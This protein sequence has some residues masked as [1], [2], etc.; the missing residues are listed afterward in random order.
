M[1]YCR[2]LPLI[3]TFSLSRKLAQSFYY[4]FTRWRYSHL[5]T[6]SFRQTMFYDTNFLAPFGAFGPDDVDTG[7]FL[8]HISLLL[9]SSSTLSGIFTSELHQIQTP[10][11]DRG[12]R[13]DCRT[14]WVFR[15]FGSTDCA[16]LSTSLHLAL[17]IYLH[18]ALDIFH[19]LCIFP[20]CYVT[21]C[22]AHLFISFQFFALWTVLFTS[23]HL[24]TLSRSHHF[25]HDA[26]AALHS[27]T[28][29][30]IL[31]LFPIFSSSKSL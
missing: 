19:I 4:I 28:P 12:T 25:P 11:D 31:P 23:L 18:L 14:G 8:P 15:F 9:L 27:L 2:E 20:L 24:S 22:I 3:S 10:P 26:V 1:T 13:A 6:N 5:R 21:V 30:P 7:N 17:F 29:P 16:I